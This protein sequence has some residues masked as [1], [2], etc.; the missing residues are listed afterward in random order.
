M[1]IVEI[2]EADEM[3]EDAVKT[4]MSE[5]TK[6]GLEILEAAILLGILGDVLFRSTPLGLNVFLWIVGLTSAMTALTLRRRN[7]HWN[8]QTIGLHAALI[9]LA[10]MFMWRDSIELQLLDGFVILAI[11]AA[12]ILPGL[13]IKPH[14]AGVSHYVIGW[15]WSG[16]NAAFS[17]FFLVFDDIKWNSIPRA[18]WTKHL[19]SVVRGLAIAAPILLIFGALFMAADAV[20]E[21]IIQKN[22]RLSPDVLMGHL[23]LFGFFSWAVA[24]YLRGNLMTNLVEATVMESVKPQPASVTERID[25]ERETVTQEEK[26]ERQWQN[27]DNSVLP[28]S[29]S[30]GTIEIC[31]ILGLINA[32]FISFIIVQIPYLFGGF[33][34]VRQTENLKL[35]DYARRGFGELVAVAALALPILLTTHWL[36]RRDIPLTQTLYR[37]FAAIQIGLLFVIM[38]SAMQRLFILTGNLG[39]G[40]TT[41]RFYPMVFMIWLAVVFIWFGATVLRGYRSHFAWGGLW[42]GLAVLLVLH[43]INP[44]D[45]IVRR[46]LRLMQEGRGFDGYY[47]ARLSDDAVPA[48]IEALGSMDFDNQCRV[49]ARLNSRSDTVNG[50]SDIRSFNFSR[51]TARNYLRRNAANLQIEGCPENTKYP[52]ESNFEH[53]AGRE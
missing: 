22:L 45:L 14:L 6:T 31:I 29:M 15:V 19:I 21:G 28:K 36:L 35:A 47:N 37:I 8:R 42:S 23:L 39:Y 43:F 48:L 30:L 38:L 25:I 40:M 51:W 20:F 16:V 1:E 33:E 7:E 13:G 53:D 4:K 3:S 52:S 49:A 5:K 2:K 24:G 10:G 46:N 9:F 44:D 41:V 32:L 12:L 34:L 11:L 27:F 18:G 17:P 26:A 50:E